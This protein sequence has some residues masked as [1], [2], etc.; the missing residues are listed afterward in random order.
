MMNTLFT[1]K[2]ADGLQ[3]F[4]ELPLPIQLVLLAWALIVVFGGS[5]FLRRV[6]RGARRSIVQDDEGKSRRA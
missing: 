6:I 3:Y 5:R 4:G 1:G 2:L